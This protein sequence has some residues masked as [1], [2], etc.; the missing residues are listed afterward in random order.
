MILLLRIGGSDRPYETVKSVF[1]KLNEE[2]VM[3]A[4]YRIV[5]EQ[6]DMRLPQNYIR[7]CLYD[8]FISADAGYS[9]AVY[10]GRAI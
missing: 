3:Y 9:M 10:G 7:T 4:V 2:Q 8:A 5:R 1:L 6:P